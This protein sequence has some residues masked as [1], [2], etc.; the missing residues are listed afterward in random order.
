MKEG[1]RYLLGAILLWMVIPVWAEVEIDGD[2][3]FVASFENDLFASGDRWYT[4]G[5]ELTWIWPER[6][7]PGWLNRS[8]RAF[9]GFPDQGE[10]LPW[11]MSLTQGI[12][13]PEDIEDP[14]FP[15]NDRPYAGG[16]A[17]GVTAGWEEHQILSRVYL[18][19]GVVGPASGAEQ[20]QRAVHEVFNGTDPVGW[21][22]QIPNEVILLAAYERS[23]RF[24]LPAVDTDEWT[25]EWTPQVGAVVGNAFT[26]GRFG[27]FYRFGQDLPNDF[28]PPRI[29]AIPT[30]SG[31]F[32]ATAE[33]GWYFYTGLSGSYV[34]HNI[35]LDGSLFRD[36]PSVES[37]PWVGEWYTGLVW[38]WNS[39]RLSY[40]HVLRTPEFTAQSG[41]Q[42]FGSI[43]VSW[44][45]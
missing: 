26:Q 41:T 14:E 17:L 5:F 3:I 21:D 35:F 45:F 33:T 11:A 19:L 8:I 23:R 22:T 4:N 37:E 31:Y 12:F 27:G 2:G 16:L 28:G 38:Y 24:L 1:L 32:E 6:E 29:S 25:H 43:S 7:L 15:P 40:T 18:G 9:P 39:V 30:G 42:K 34:A 20:T 36:S 13:T 10:S 44:Q